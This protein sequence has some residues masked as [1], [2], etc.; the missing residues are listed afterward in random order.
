MKNRPSLAQHFDAPD[1]YVGVFGW[2]CGYSG[3]AQFLN[4]AAERFTRLS[5]SQ[6]EAQGFVALAVMF[7]P[8]NPSISFRDA[9][10]IAHLPLKHL[11]DKPFLLLHAKVA[12]LGYRQQESPDRWRMR[13]LVSTGNWTRQTLEESLDLIWRIEVDS[14][15]LAKQGQDCTDISAVWSLLTWLRDLFDVRLL[16][17]NEIGKTARQEMELWLE[18]CKK[19]ARGTQRFFDNRIASLLQQLPEKVVTYGKVRRN[20][21]SMGSGFYEGSG[22]TQSA[23]NT[24]LQIRD[25]LIKNQL[26]TKT[27]E[28]DLF[29]KPQACQGVAAGHAA[30]CKE[31]FTIRP[32]AVPDAIFGDNAQ[33]SLHAKFLFSANCREGSNNCS[34]PWIYLGSGN[35]TPAGFAKQMSPHG[36]NLEA[37]VVFAPKRLYR[38]IA[39]GDDSKSYV[40]TN[41]LPIQFEDKLEAADQLQVGGEFVSGEAIYLAPPIAWLLWHE[42]GEGTELQTD[43]ALDS[44]CAVDVLDMSDNP[45]ARTQGG[46]RWCGSQPR[47]VAIRWQS[48]GE[49]RRAQIPVVDAF[50]RIA[51]TPLRPMDIDEA[52]WQLA[53][54]PLPPEED[55][56][57]VSEGDEDHPTKANGAGAPTV[58]AQASS[59][60]RQM[61]ELIENIAARQTALDVRDWPLWCARLEQTLTQAKDSAPV[62]FFRETLDLN[63]LHAL[64]QPSFRPAFAESSATEEGKRYEDTLRRIG[65]SWRVADLGKLGGAL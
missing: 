55:R 4:D 5:Q 13:L 36:G 60:I 26:L 10:G 58:A 3:D 25:A 2:V 59:P 51:A 46:F 41:L 31:G 30:L 19:C 7:D 14:E 63:P 9:P 40:V 38:R 8:S 23:P 28:L 21:L 61:M 1:D 45:C 15:T 16:N 47:Q 54:F 24:P 62:A 20:Y 35:L 27:P 44:S 33:R 32:A 56:E 37:G 52:W 50:G 29:V 22:A 53:D 43:V 34:S 65:E 6:R 18:T 57:A 17:A 64:A 49:T 11:D 48:E 39:A 12:L 42:V